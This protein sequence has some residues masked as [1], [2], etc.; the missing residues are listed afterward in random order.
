MIALTTQFAGK[1]VKLIAINC[2]NRSEDLEAMTKH[3]ADGGLNYPY[4]FDATGASARAFGARV[5]PHFFVLDGN[6]QVVY[7]GAFDDDMRAPQAHYVADAVT[8]VL[9][10]KAPETAT[11]KAFGCG[12]RIKR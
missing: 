6:R 11:T 10:G 8:A 1:G 5:T 7:R 12:L 4:A 9:A 2:N 3:A